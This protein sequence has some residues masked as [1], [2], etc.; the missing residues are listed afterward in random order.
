[1]QLLP[2]AATSPRSPSDP[3]KMNWLRKASLS[4][5]NTVIQAHSMPQYRSSPLLSELQPYHTSRL[6]RWSSIAINIGKVSILHGTATGDLMSTTRPSCPLFFKDD[7]KRGIAK[8][9]DSKAY[10]VLCPAG[11]GAGTVNESSG[12]LC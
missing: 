4:G 3:P 11:G 2:V 1:M 5:G 7:I 12:A 9:H 10:L 6:C 8:K